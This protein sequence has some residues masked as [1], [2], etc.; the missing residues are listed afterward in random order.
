[1]FL[2]RVLVGRITKGDHTM[3]DTPPIPASQNE[4]YDSTV[5]NVNHPT[6]F[7]TFRDYRAY[8]DYLI[9]FKNKPNNDRNNCY[10]VIQ[11]NVRNSIV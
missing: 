10:G 9:K 7:V 2:C 5:D 3:I 1:M 11:N 8:A 6:I 4:L